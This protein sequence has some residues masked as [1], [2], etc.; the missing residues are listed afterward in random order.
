MGNGS[1]LAP[2]LCST[3]TAG[4]EGKFAAPSGRGQPV[5]PSAH[6]RLQRRRAGRARR[7]L[8]LGRAMLFQTRL[9]SAG[10]ELSWEAPRMFGSGL[11]F[12]SLSIAAIFA[13]SAGPGT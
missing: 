8:G 12:R 6:E 5:R 10:M 4:E 7:V 11:A 9:N 13:A 3:G 2:V 1:P